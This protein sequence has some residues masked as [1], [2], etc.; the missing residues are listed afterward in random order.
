MKSSAI[1][2]RDRWPSSSES[3]ATRIDTEKDFRAMLSLVAP[4]GLL[5]VVGSAKSTHPP[6]R[7]NDVAGPV[8]VRLHRPWHTTAPIVGPPRVTDAQERRDAEDLPPG[9]RYRRRPLTTRQPLLNLR[10]NGV[11][12][13]P[14]VMRRL[15]GLSIG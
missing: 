8:A 9:V 6:D 12:Q 3:A 5:F 4:G 11:S 7:P 10:D 2:T 13:P 1:V 15:L 14:P